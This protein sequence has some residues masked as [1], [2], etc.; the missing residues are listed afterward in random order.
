VLLAPFEPEQFAILTGLPPI[1]VPL[2]FEAP[3]SM[4]KAVGAIFAFA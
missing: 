3:S 2:V 1:L 4:F